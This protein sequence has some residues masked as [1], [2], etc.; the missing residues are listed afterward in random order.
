MVLKTFEV[1][2]VTVACKPL[3]PEN[4]ADFGSIISANHQID[5][6][7]TSANYGTAIK[8][9]KVSLISN[10]FDQAPSGS[11]AT[12]NWNIFRCSPP[13]HLLKEVPE[14]RIYLSKV[15]ERHPFSS[16]TF[17]P[18]GVD[19]NNLCAYI[20]ICAKN[21]VDG[22]P[23]PETVEAF[24]CKGDQAVTYA[25]GTWHAPMV[26]L[27]DKLDFG[28]LINENK[29]DDENCQECYF[30]PGFHILIPDKANL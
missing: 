28:V 4:F 17:L 21:S 22:L 8:A 9:H 13:L 23:D 18:M 14:G 29:I 30:N 2:G 6:K 24:Y 1:S 12:I 20:V 15:L 27:V 11:K 10:H 16:Q 3:T 5:E 19:K 7:S 26:S 25:P